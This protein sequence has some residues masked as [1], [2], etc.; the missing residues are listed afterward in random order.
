MGEHVTRGIGDAGVQA[1]VELV[2]RV[3]DHHFHG[4]ILK[5]P[6]RQS[7]DIRER[8]IRVDLQAAGRGERTGEA[9]MPP[10]GNAATVRETKGRTV[11]EDRI[12]RRGRAG[13]IQI[14]RASCR[15]R[16]FRTV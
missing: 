5:R 10:V 14:G 9:V 2:G 15:E 13:L 16:V 3:R 12:A 6:D 8:R 4:Q 1:H 7:I 11:V